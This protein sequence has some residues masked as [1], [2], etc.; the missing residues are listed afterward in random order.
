MTDI[1]YSGLGIAWLKSFGAKR[2]RVPRPYT[3]DDLLNKAEWQPYPDLE[4]KVQYLHYGVSH[5]LFNLHEIGMGVL[6]LL[7]SGNQVDTPSSDSQIL[8]TSSRLARVREIEQELE[9][10]L[11]DLPPEVSAD[12]EL[13]PRAP[14]QM[15]LLYGNL[16]HLLMVY[17]DHSTG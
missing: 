1:S 17:S 14:A 9:D 10:W 12:A 13:L 11:H 4:P 3:G 7:L 15:D 6:P 5:Y 16:F 2:P 8:D